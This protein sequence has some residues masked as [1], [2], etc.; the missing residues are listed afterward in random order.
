MDGTTLRPWLEGT[1]E[2]ERPV[3]IQYDGNGALGNFQRCV[4][5]GDYKLVTDVFKDEVFYELYDVK[6][7]RME[8]ENLMFTAEGSKKAG[9]LY[10]MMRHHMEDIGDFLVLPEP[11]FEEFCSNYR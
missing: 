9:E 3:F 11:D 6:N 10:E 4:I 5:S 7:D 8:T 2:K 1:A